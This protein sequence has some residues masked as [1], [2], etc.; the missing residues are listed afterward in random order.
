MPQLGYT[1]SPES[2]KFNENGRLNNLKCK[3]THAKSSFSKKIL[4][5]FLDLIL[6]FKLRKIFFNS[7]KYILKA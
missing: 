3:N 1:T 5:E 4:T 6:D 7:Y 2:I